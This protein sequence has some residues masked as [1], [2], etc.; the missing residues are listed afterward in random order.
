MS[1]DITIM[2]V[3]NGSIKPAATLML[4]ELA[5]NLSRKS[6]YKIHAVSLRH[7]DCI[8]SD[9]LEGKSAHTFVPFLTQKLQSGK[10]KFILLPLF[11]SESS[12]VTS[13]VPEQIKLLEAQFGEIHLTIADV[14][15]PLPEGDSRLVTILFDYIQQ[16]IKSISDKQNIVLVDHGSPSP[17]VT[18][19]RQHI[20]AA[21]QQQ[22]DDIV[23]EQA[24]MERGT[25][26]DFNGPLLE[27]WLTEKAIK[28][29]KNAIIALMFF[30]PGKHAGEAGDIE[31]ICERIKKQYPEFNI[32]IAPLI[33]EH[34]ELI[35]ILFSRLKVA[36][37]RVAKL[38]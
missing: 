31:K 22:I 21:L 4:R 30:L 16:R 29:E 36:V 5:E 20:A 9:Q 28:G 37:T 13:F 7:A 27:S 3:D 2:L 33:A 1:S 34:A 35:E 23:I 32:H 25:E 6:K 12:A 26:Y 11:F 8:N 17:K 19:V 38:N 18:A 10:H 24:V 14:V 15:Y